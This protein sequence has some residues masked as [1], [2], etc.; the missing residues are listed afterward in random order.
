MQI[1]RRRLVLS[2]PLILTANSHSRDAPKIVIGILARAIYH[3]IVLFVNQ[4]LALVLTHF[5]IWGQLDGVGR[6]GLFAESAKNTTRKVN[7][8]KLRIPPAGLVFS[9]LQGNAAH[10]AGD[11][12]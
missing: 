4:V 2:L 9:R 5:K 8:E 6:A 1:D 12:A 10:R 3:Q 11:S 7:T